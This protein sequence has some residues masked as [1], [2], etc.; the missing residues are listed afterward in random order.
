MR[1]FRTLLADLAMLTRNTMPMRLGEAVPLTVLSRPTTIQQRAVD[2]LGVALASYAERRPLRCRS[3]G[4][5]T[6]YVQKSCR[7]SG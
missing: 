4:K 7:S 6:P 1:S 3:L 2:L 5:S